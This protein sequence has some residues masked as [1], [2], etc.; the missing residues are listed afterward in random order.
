MATL[1]TWD[2]K[3]LPPP[4]RGKPVKI[5]RVSAESGISMIV[6]GWD[7]YA[8]S[9][10]EDA[11]GVV[12]ET[13]GRIQADAVNEAPVYLAKLRQSVRLEPAGPDAIR[14]V[15]GGP[16]AQY[17]AFIEYGTRSGRPSIEALE[18]WM[19]RKG[20]SPKIKSTHKG[21]PYH[22]AAAAIQKK[23]MRSGIKGKAFFFPALEKN[24][25]FFVDEMRKVLK[26]A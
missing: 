4:K 26:G 14:I 3:W 13:A 17:A 5:E 25:Q 20:I 11:R 18:N 9:M 16:A 7:T 10:K 12:K 23:I 19:R 1:F 24:R 8:E 21:R 2:A 22:E 15:A 6:K